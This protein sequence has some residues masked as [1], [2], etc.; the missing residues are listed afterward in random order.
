MYRY[1][2]ILP[3]VSFGRALGAAN[4]GNALGQMGRNDE[5]LEKFTV[6]LKIKQNVYGY[7]HPSMADI[8]NSV[9]NVQLAMGNF[10]ASYDAYRDAM[11]IRS[12]VFGEDHPSVYATL[13]NLGCVLGQRG[14][15]L[16]W[17]DKRR[18]VGIKIQ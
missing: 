10:N 1:V 7:N 15:T 13:G 2:P 3:V 4:I 8:H 11:Q 5:A 18:L 6:A 9:G 12:S 14:D 17:R 16:L